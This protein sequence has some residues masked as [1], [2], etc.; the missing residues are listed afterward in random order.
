MEDVINACWKITYGLYMISSIDGD[1]W[2]GQICNTLFQVT[3]DPPR[4]AIAINHN[5][6]THEFIEKSGIFAATILGRDDHRMVRR[7]GYRSGRD[8]DK[9]KGLDVREVRNGCPVLTGSV[10]YFEYVLI[11]GM[12]VNAGTHSIF[13][14]DVTGGGVLSGGEPMT[15][16][17]YHSVKKKQE[18]R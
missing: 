11:P 9:F 13:V 1:R 3:S 4:M 8:F 10:G 16:E 7:F 15:Y 12:T 2:N 14:G 17:H 6:L 5:N 18:D